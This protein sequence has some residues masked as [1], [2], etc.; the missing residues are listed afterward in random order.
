MLL[1]SCAG[2]APGAERKPLSID[3]SSLAQAQTPV[4]QRSGP[5]ITRVPY[6]VAGNGD[7][8]QNWGDLYLP[9]GVHKAGS[10]P[11]VVLIHGGAWHRSIGAGDFSYFAQDLVGRGVAVYNIEYRRV[12]SGGGWPTTFTDVASSLGHVPDIVDQTPELSGKTEVVGHSAGAQLATWAGSQVA[13][14]EHQ[15]GKYASFK[16]DRIVALS[17]PLDMTNA[18]NFSDLDMVNAVG[19]TPLTAASRYEDVDPI[20]NLAPGIP[21]VAVHGTADT[22]VSWQN[23]QRY[24][25]ALLQAGGNGRLDLLYGDTHGSLIT[26]GTAHYQQVLETVADE[27]LK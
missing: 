3:E 21:V 5:E 15:L 27:L 25:Q 4:S 1:A 24:I 23:S 22:T 6:P 12:G 20:Q 10:V 11:L 2:S 18:A 17:G 14:P 16:P 13:H 8:S 19:G 7:P 26:S 9:A